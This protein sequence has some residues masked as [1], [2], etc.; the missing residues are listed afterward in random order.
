L[1]S[2][3]VSIDLRDETEI[4]FFAQ[5]NAALLTHRKQTPAQVAAATQDAQ[6]PAEPQAYTG[7]QLVKSEPAPAPVKP[8]VITP[9]AF[10]AAFRAYYTRL[11]TAAAR[12]LLDK[13]QAPFLKDV[14]VDRRAEFYAEVTA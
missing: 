5:L 10:E 8:P 4:A 7:P 1:S 13:Y 12:A 2:V 11:G 14:P 6:P 3:T 9:E